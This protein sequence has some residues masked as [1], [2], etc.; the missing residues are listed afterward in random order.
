MIT[1]E[2]LAELLDAWRADIDSDP[3]PDLA[4]EVAVA[5]RDF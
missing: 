3:F 5:N 4:K 2:R 1:V